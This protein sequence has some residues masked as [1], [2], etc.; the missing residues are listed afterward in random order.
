LPLSLTQLI[1]VF[2]AARLAFLLPLPGRL[3][4]WKAARY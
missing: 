1:G 2:L 4:L 3:A